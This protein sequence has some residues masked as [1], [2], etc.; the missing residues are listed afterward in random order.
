MRVLC[1]CGREMQP[2]EKH[3]QEIKRKRDKKR[4]VVKP[5]KERERAGERKRERERE[6]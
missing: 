5:N 6:T 3:N 4:D 2:K 1:V